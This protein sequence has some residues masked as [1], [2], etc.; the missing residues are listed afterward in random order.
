[1]SIPCGFDRGGL[2]IGLQILGHYFAEAKLLDVAHQFQQ[3]TDWHKAPRSR[4]RA[5]CPRRP[6]SAWAALRRSPY[7]VK[8]R[9]MVGSRHRPRDARAAVHRVEDLL[10]RVDAFG[11]APNTQAS[12]GGH[13][14]ARR[15]AGAEPRRGR[16]RDPLRA[17]GRRDDHRRSVF[18]RKN[19][20]YP[21]LPKG[22]QIS[23]YEM[24]VVAGRIVT[25][26]MHAT[27]RS[28]CASRARTSRR[29]RASRCT[30]TSTA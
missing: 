24:P 9:V 15:A 18:A 23:Q 21:D 2:P 14:A 5:R 20:F 30:R 4:R 22:Y 11:A 25:I 28:A 16:A 10:G 26:A 6:M 27:A 8:G 29:T 1:M 19:Y 12:R 17:G 13:R 7:A 3:A